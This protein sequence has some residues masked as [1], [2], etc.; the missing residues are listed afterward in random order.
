M[1]KRM[2]CGLENNF[3]KLTMFAEFPDQ[4]ISMQHEVL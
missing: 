3:Y 4:N 1:G 2:F